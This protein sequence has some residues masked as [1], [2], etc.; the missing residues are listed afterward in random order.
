MRKA[1]RDRISDRRLQTLLKGLR[2]DVAAPADFRA[3]VLRRLQA[4]GLL[5][6]PVQAAPRS[7]VRRL[8]AQVKGMAGMAPARWGLGLGAAAAA[9]WA[10]VGLAPQA[11]R[12]SST[13]S[14]AQAQAPARAIQPEAPVS[15]P[16]SPAPLSR[17]PA[18]PPRQ[19]PAAPQ[20]PA[21][22]EVAVLESAA[23]ALD[24]ALGLGEPEAPTQALQVSA[25]TFKPTVVVPTPTPLAKALQASSEV[26]NNVLRASRGESALILFRLAEAGR[27]RVEVRDRLGRLVA[28]LADRDFGAGQHSLGWGGGADE[29][30]MAASGVY[31]LRIKGPGLEASHKVAVVR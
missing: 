24:P 31:Q 23:P 19:A 6:G 13:P 7:W 22:V 28:V 15:A 5:A 26:R 27:V 11:P 1:H 10:L 25:A 18:A 3:G 8:A 2:E 21:P 12:S 20:A 4:Q 29:G 9:A 16:Q 14:L 30:A 17:R